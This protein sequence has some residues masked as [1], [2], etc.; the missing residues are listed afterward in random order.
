M[1]K[2]NLFII[3]IE[4]RN[5]VR[6]FL[7]LDDSTPI[8]IMYVPGPGDL[9]ETYP[10]WKRGE[11]YPGKAIITYS[12]MFFDVVDALGAQA[13]IVERGEDHADEMRA[14]DCTFIRLCDIDCQSRGAYWPDKKSLTRQIAE[15]CERYEPHILVIGGDFY[16]PMLPR[17]ARAS[18]RIILSIHN[19]F[20][21]IG[22]RPR[23]L[24]DQSNFLVKK[25]LV[26]RHIDAAVAVSEAAMKQFQEIAP[27]EIPGFRSMHQLPSTLANNSDDMAQRKNQICY[28]GR[29][30]REKGVF[31]LLEAFCAVRPKHPD[32]K[33]RFIGTGTALEDLREKAATTNFADDIEALGPVGAAA[34]YSVLRESRLLVV[35]T[36]R[37]FAEGFPAVCAEAISQKTP[38]LVSSVVPAREVF[39]DAVVEFEA[40]NSKNLAECLML[41]LGNEHKLE[42]MRKAASTAREMLFDRS[43]SWGSALAQAIVA[44]AEG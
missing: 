18:G 31:D 38:L 12:E 28:L 43:N 21:Q 40:E 7:G 23:G 33:I 42:D 30:E 16:W 3:P 13:L 4:F 10:F 22:R 20:W 41:L 5:R 19:M 39:G 15:H 14:D 17:L 35:P 11:P 37:A 44:S 6:R 29:V 36:Q 34:V 26:G 32:L 25:L 24:K 27:R 2:E 1:D 8:R 9:R